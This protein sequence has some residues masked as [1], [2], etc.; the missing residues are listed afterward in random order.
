LKIGLIGNMNN[1]NFAMMRYFRDLGADA[2]LLLYSN[3]GKGTLS[4]FTP[5]ADTWELQRWAPFIART[6][7]PNSPVSALDFPASW[8][9]GWRQLAHQLLGS[10]ESLD[11]P[12]TRAEVSRA[13]APYQRLLG[14]GIS[15]AL[16][17]RIGRQLDLFYPYAL[18][19]EFLAWPGWVRE[20]NSSSRSRR[21]LTR[22]VRAAQVRGVR[23]S[24]VVVSTDTVTRT[25]LSAIGV[26][27][28]DSLIPM[29]YNRETLSTAP[30]SQR[31]ARMSETIRT[32]RFTVLHHARLM[33]SR[34]TQRAE[35]EHLLTT[36]NS[37][38]LIRAFTALMSARPSLRPRLFVVEYGP[39]V[40]AT[41]EIVAQ[42]GIE[43]SVTWIPK[44][45]RRELIWLL[46]NVSVGVGE[47]MNT[48]GM[49]WGGTGWE[50]L[51][52][53]KPL[54]QSFNFE[55]GEFA[56]IYGHP[57]PPM[58]P[59]KAEE[60]VLQHLLFAADHPE[61]AAEIGR[62]AREWFDTYN[63]IALAKK[64]LAL[65]TDPP[66]SAQPATHTPC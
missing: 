34:Q 42:L 8:C 13:F 32:S 58:L 23:E 40:G 21:I 41:K 1:N 63:G 20:C 27:A 17:L 37:D 16:L 51:A 60:D 3:D 53:G 49:I 33:W 62:R 26:L 48:R 64:W 46:G 50:T 45:A 66:D 47:F 29:V 4:H 19:V 31:L 35:D 28:K 24:K 12:V 55:D 65:L 56:S 7:I 14:S 57:P 2:H 59:V 30:P 11:I 43:D 25:A 54:L 39:D 15:P 61:Q 6:T 22:A 9:L 10:I 36:K 44:M 52:S 38:W 5:E 18:G